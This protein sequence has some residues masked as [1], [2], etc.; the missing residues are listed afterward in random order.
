MLSF[1]IKI[2]KPVFVFT[3]AA[4]LTTACSGFFDKD[5]TPAPTPLTSYKP[6]IAPELRWSARIGQGANKHDY[7]KMSPR[8]DSHAI[9]TAS[10]DGVVTAIKKEN[11]QILWQSNLR[12]SLSSG[13]GIGDGLVV[14]ANHQGDVFALNASHG[15]TQWQTQVA[16]DIIA[17]PAIGD[18]TVIIKSVNGLITSLSTS[19]GTTLWAHQQTEPTLLLRGASAPLIK[20]HYTLVGYANGSLAKMNVRNGELAWLQTVAI[21]E[22]AF[23]IQRMIDIDA[24]PILFQYRIYVAT[25]QGNLASLDFTSGKVRWSQQLSS[26]SGMTADES[27]VYVSDANGHL[28]AFND[29]NGQINWQQDKLAYRRLSG[30]ASLGRFLVLGD[31][32]G[33][34]HFITKKD[35][36]LAGRVT[37]GSAAIYAT[38]LTDDQTVYALTSQGYLAAYRI[39]Y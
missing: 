26:Y 17:A 20:D 30:P 6:E 18:G 37:L 31:G 2:T 23:A 25:Y 27:T 35:G 16:G 19:T 32:E 33:Y 28:Y 3:C 11:G 36:H 15:K 38:P 4:I 14:V 10:T 12:H 22:G 24:D 8:M 9:Y 5:N 34:L 39:R 7:L 1:F 13:V 21:P 29:Y